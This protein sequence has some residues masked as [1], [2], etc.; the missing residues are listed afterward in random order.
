[1]HTVTWN[2]IAYFL[3]ATA[4]IW[5]GLSVLRSRALRDRE[6]YDRSVP[7]V[8]RVLKIGKTTASRSYGAMV[9][10]LLLQLHRSGV[11]PY[12]LS[13]IWS[14]EPSA[15]PKVQVGQT[16]AVKIDPLDRT[17]IYSAEK[18]ARS[19]GVMKTPIK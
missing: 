5:I 7:G 17:K 6:S 13:T 18:W 12:E 10:D 2:Y 19:L 16:F 1:M 9:M 8:A 14:V 3:A 4:L 11:E 15:V